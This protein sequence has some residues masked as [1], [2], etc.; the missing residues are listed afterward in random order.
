M[1]LVELAKAGVDLVRV[2]VWPF[3]VVFL[4]LKF[5]SPLFEILASLQASLQRADKAE[6]TGPGGWGAKWEQREA[7]ANNPSLG[8]L[9]KLSEPPQLVASHRP[10]VTRLENEMRLQLKAFDP[11]KRED[12]L[13][14]AVAETR[15]RAGH[16]FIYNRIFGSQIA[17]LERLD[18]RGSLTVDEAREFFKP[19]ADKYP[20]LYNNYG[21]DLWLNFMTANALV[22]RDGDTLTI[23]EIGHDFLVYITD[24]R[25][26]R[27]KL[28]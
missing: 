19:Y 7:A 23:D 6:L 20:Q 12:L 2:A 18:G 9:E 1:A 27:N 14:R 4:A 28:G 24:Q 16:E 26:S 13:L 10:A 3:A 22:L 5:K 11:E 25:L 8:R 21:F 17:F 15:L